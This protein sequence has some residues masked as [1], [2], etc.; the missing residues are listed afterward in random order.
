MPAKIVSVFIMV[1]LAVLFS[2]G[3]QPRAVTT[4]QAEALL[5]DMPRL[6]GINIYFSEAFR[7]ASRFDRSNQG[8]SR[9]AGLLR[10]QGASLFTLEWRTGFPTDADLVVVAGPQDGYSAL[11]T[12]R[13]WAYLNNNGRVLILTTTTGR[14][15]EAAPLGARS[16]L[17]QLMWSDFGVQA[18]DSVVMT[19]GNRLADTDATEEAPMP[20]LVS[21]FNVGSGNFNEEHPITAALT[22]D[23][24][25]FLSRPIQADSSIQPFFVT[26]LVVSDD[27]YY[28]ES[29]Y[30]LFAGQGIA[31][32]NINQDTSRG[33]QN[34]AVALEDPQGGGRL[35]L[36]GDRNFAINGKGFE[37]SP[38]NSAGFIYPGNVRFM[39]NSVAWLLE[40]E[41]VE[42]DFP[43]PGPT[44][45]A[46]ITPSPTPTPTVTPG[47]S[48]TPTPT[49]AQ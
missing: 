3:M 44:A 48:P 49:A 34:L 36:L 5:Q 29:R 40:Q 46:T 22:D 17:M 23:L 10:Q 38:P 42:I 25:F 6:D 4:V 30:D 16:G 21:E 41:P 7:E 43:T 20:A 24:R 14:E 15:D 32:Y 33:A 18:L 45:T 47:P 11:P 27:I 28:G 1:M 8:I 12:S 2:L 35:V 13:L 37:V 26:P 39:L 31:E 19:E 9:F